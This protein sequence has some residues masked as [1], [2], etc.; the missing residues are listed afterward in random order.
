MSSNIITFV[1]VHFCGTADFVRTNVYQRHYKVTAQLQNIGMAE[2]F[3]EIL[4]IWHLSVVWEISAKNLSRKYVQPLTA[5]KN[6]PQRCLGNLS[7][8]I[9]AI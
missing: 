2:I 9:S 6:P 8:K 5:L 1:A 7:Q 4:N 3:A